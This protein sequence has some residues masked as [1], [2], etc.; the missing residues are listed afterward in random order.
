MPMIKTVSILCNYI[1]LVVLVGVVFGCQNDDTPIQDDSLATL[2]ANYDTK[3]DNV[4]AC[5]ATSLVATDQIEAF[6]YPR[7]GVTDLRYFETDSITVDK[8]DYQNYTQIPLEASAVF[9]GHLQKFTRQLTQEKWVIITFLEAGVLQLSNPIRLKHN[10]RPTEF[11]TAVT[12]DQQQ[13]TMPRFEWQDGIYQDNTIYFQV[14]S[15]ANNDL[16]SGTY[17]LDT[18]FQYYKTANV[19]LNVTESTPP[20]LV[21]GSDYGFTLMGVSEDNWV[22]LWIEKSFTITP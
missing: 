13:P 10:T 21:N 22:N 1:L 15:N 19:V 3:I 12:I 8:N 11:S 2:V 14:L 5:A 7:P 18:H 16:L 20:A 4:I 9:N 17:T 6:V